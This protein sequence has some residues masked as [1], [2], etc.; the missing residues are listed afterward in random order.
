LNEIKGII[1][2]NENELE[3]IIVYEL[4]FKLLN[5]RGNIIDVSGHI[6]YSDKNKKYLK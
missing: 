6:K 3:L 5:F 2:N 4:N 1:Y